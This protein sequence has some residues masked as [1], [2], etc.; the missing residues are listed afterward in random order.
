[1]TMGQLLFP[2]IAQNANRGQFF[3][4]KQGEKAMNQSEVS[5]GNKFGSVII[6]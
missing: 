1:M 6:D 5:V 2:R 4:E 3:M